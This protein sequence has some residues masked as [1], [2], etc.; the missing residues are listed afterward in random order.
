MTKLGEGDKEAEAATRLVD[1]KLRAPHLFMREQG[2]VHFDS[3]FENILI[4]DG[5]IYFTDFG[6]TLSSQFDLTESERKFLAH[7]QDYDR[8]N[9]IMTLMICLMTSQYS[10]HEGPWE[11]RL[12]EYLK[13]PE[14]RMPAVL[15]SIIRRDA[16]IALGLKQFF[17]DL[18]L[19]KSVPYPSIIPMTDH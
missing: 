12:Q 7:H 19:D 18:T 6:L 17:K 15:D 3:H 13:S 2:F 1:E 11:T 8:C 4:E 5:Q 10:K 16:A 9:S 14:S